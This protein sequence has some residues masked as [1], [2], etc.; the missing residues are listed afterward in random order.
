MLGDGAILSIIVG[1]FFAFLSGVMLRNI[2]NP[3]R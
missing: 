1:A 2:T 3:D